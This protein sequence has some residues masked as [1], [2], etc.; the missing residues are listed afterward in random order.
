MFST[1]LKPSNRIWRNSIGSKN[2]MSSTKV[3]FLIGKQ[4]WLPWPLIGWDNFDF[5][6]ITQQNLRKLNRKLEFDKAYKEARTQHPLPSLCFLGRL[7]NLESCLPRLLIGCDIFPFFFLFWNRWTEFGKT[8]QEARTQ[9]S[10]CW[11]LQKPRWDTCTCSM[12]ILEGGG[13]GGK[14]KCHTERCQRHS[15]CHYHCDII[16]PSKMKVQQ[17]K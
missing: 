15:S 2:Y 17:S 12:I 1:S 9:P 7:E 16:C 10:F 11:L 5:F 6:E 4:R 8:W 3:V 14:S 13:G